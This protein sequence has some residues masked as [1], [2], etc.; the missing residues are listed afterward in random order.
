MPSLAEWKV[1]AG[2][3]AMGLGLFTVS[4][5]I[6]GQVLTGRSGLGARRSG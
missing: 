6:A 2:I 5:K 4:V 1:T 3:W